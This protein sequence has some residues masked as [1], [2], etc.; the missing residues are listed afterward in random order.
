MVQ[1]KKTVRLMYAGLLIICATVLSSGAWSLWHSWQNSLHRAEKDAKNQSLSLSRQAQDTFLQVQLTLEELARNANAIFT[2]PMRFSGP[3]GLLAIQ[4]GSLPQL[5][6]LF[7]YD[8]QGQLLATTATRAPPPVSDAEKEYFTWHRDHNDMRL[9]IGHVLKSGAA[10][11][12]VIPVSLRL[13]DA[14]G[15]FR[16]LVL[17]TVSVD[18]FRQ[19]YGWYELGK[20]DLLGL[21]HADGTILY[22]RPLPDAII[23]RSIAD[24]PLFTQRAG[25]L[26]NGTQTWKNRV[27]GVERI[28]GHARPEHYSLVAV[29]AYDRNALALAWFRNNQALIL[30]NILLL[31]MVLFCGIASI[32]QFRITVIRHNELLKTQDALTQANHTLQDLAL[33]DGLTGTGNRRQFDIYLEQCMAR[34]AQSDAPVTLMMIDIDYFKNYNDTYGHVA[35]DGCLIKVANLLK[36]LPRRSTDIVTRYGGEEFAIILPASGTHEA[37]MLAQRALERLRRAALPHETTKLAEKRIT[38]SIGISTSEPGS[39][40]VALK[41]AAD[42]AL[43]AAKYAGRNRIVTTRELWSMKM[44]GS[45]PREWHTPASKQ[46]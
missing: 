15:Q 19:V 14:Q 24:S 22:I 38:L 27:D 30:L 18:F 11:K 7:V 8:A 40:A 37:E 35:G 20:G 44:A 34:A 5:S 6:G 4:Q 17:A 39:D 36:G 29:A 16:G 41:Q 3:Q 43:Y 2:S 28:V 9:H 10:D 45:L 12:L 33:L 1:M 25:R 42:T 26:P 31:F 32:R 23:N 46:G 21:I 13:N